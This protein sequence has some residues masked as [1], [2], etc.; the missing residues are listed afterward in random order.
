MLHTVLVA[1]TLLINVM[2]LPFD[3]FDPILVFLPACAQ[4]VFALVL[5]FLLLLVF[6]LE[7][8]LA[9]VFVLILLFVHRLCLC[10]FF[11]LLFCV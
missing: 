5:V 7:P 3:L 1:G 6:L 2:S 10:L 4:F 8:L 9:V 11:C